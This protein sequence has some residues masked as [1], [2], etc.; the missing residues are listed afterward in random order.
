VPLEIMRHAVGP[1]LDAMVLGAGR[2]TPD[3]AMSIGLVH[4][5]LE[6]DQLL[7]AALRRADGLC[8]APADVFAL[9]KRQLHGPAR[10]RIDTAG[11]SD[12]PQVLKMWGS[13]RTRQSLRDYLAS[14]RRR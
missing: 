2:L 6:P 12:D 10:G 11:P 8:A 4:E 1:A 5:V 14:L 3:Q 9:A 13:E 7:A